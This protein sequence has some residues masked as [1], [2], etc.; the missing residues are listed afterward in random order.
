M[1]SPPTFHPN[2]LCESKAIGSGT[3]IWAFAH[4]LR[5]AVIGSDNNICDHVFIENDV[6]IGDRV[7]VKCG[8]Q[9]WDGIRVED[10][11]FIGPNAT[12]TN[13][14]FP[15]SRVPRK[16]M[17]PTLI[18]RG[19]SI[20]ANATIL[21][22]VTVGVGAMVGAGTVITADVPANA[23]VVGNPARIIGYAGSEVISS[24]SELPAEA[25]WQ[26]FTT[27]INTDSRGRLS[28]WSLASTLPFV[29]QRLYVIDGAPDGWARGGG[30]YVRSHQFLLATHG[31]LTVAMDNGRQ[32]DMICLSSPDR[33][34]YV[35]PGIWTLQFGHSADAA[36]LVLASE[37]YDP[38]ERIADYDE[39]LRAS[40]PG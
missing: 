29:P 21:P 16:A 35:P 11:V 30:A 25:D 2:A 13:D 26:I 24:Q 1:S 32:R 23:V 38:S 14:L 8:V 28:A 15:R 7:T 34:L 40:R 33:G 37:L 4:I 36:L 5:G 18:R 22:G 39:F 6:V 12:F 27:Q 3:R 10:D 9:L 20:G 19:A 17:P 31:T